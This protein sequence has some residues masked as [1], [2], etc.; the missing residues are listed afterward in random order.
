MPE[1]IDLYPGYIF[2]DYQ[3]LERGQADL[4]WVNNHQARLAY[5]Y[6][7]RLRQFSWNVGGSLR[8]GNNDFGAQYQINPFLI[9][10]DAF[11]PVRSA[12]Y[13]LNGGVDRYLKEISMRFALGAGVNARREQ[14][15]LNGEEP[16]TLY[17]RNYLVN[18]SCGT[19]FDG[20]VNAILDSRLSYA[21]ISTPAGPGL[22]TAYWFSTLQILVKPSARLHLKVFVHHTANRTGPAPYQHFYAADGLFLLRFPKWR[23]ELEMTAFNLLGSRRFEQASADGFLQSRI[24]VTAVRRFFLLSWSVN[25]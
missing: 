3:T 4:G 14:T 19:A 5:R 6:N 18:A 11:R 25:F 22:Q 12:S 9:V 10:R 7:D 2:T 1:L 17:T 8:Q 13:A 23:S 15:R 21:V 16:R 20:W 24:A